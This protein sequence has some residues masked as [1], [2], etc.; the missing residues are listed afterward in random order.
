MMMR[1]CVLASLR[2]YDMDIVIKWRK[3]HLICLSS[4][5]MSWM[6]RMRNKVEYGTRHHNDQQHTRIS[7]Q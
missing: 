1:A 4:A 5:K 6:L 2:Y 3:V 7:L